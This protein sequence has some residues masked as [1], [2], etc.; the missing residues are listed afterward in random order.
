MLSLWDKIQVSDG[1]WPTGLSRWTCEPPA[2]MPEQVSDPWVPPPPL[3]WWDIPR[4]HPSPTA[5]PS[6]L[7]D[8]PCQ[9]PPPVLRSALPHSDS[10]PLP[11]SFGSNHAVLSSICWSG[12]LP[13][14]HPSCC[15]IN[16][17]KVVL[18]SWLPCCLFLHL[19]HRRPLTPS[20]WHPT[21]MLTI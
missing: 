17:L 21:Q 6:L 14:S 3:S 10:L 12:F 16:G 5:L 20:H 8:P 13:L 4:E 11:G 7:W 2:V 19:F 9:S 18:A 15:S 1:P